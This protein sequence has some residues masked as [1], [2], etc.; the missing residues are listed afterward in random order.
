MSFNG[1]SARLLSIFIAEQLK[2]LKIKQLNFFF[3][4]IKRTLTV[5]ISSNLSKLKGVKIIVRG[6]LSKNIRAK[7][8][9][10]TVGD[11]AVQTLDSNIDYHQTTIHNANGSYGVK[12]WIVEK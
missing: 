6:R 7:H 4:F 5:L 10:L 12:V 3:A 11:V 1:N 2:I 8:K 9:I